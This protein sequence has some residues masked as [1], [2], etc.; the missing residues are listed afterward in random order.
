[1]GVL[2]RKNPLGFSQGSVK[3]PSVIV[4]VLSKGTAQ[5]DRT[6]KKDRYLAC[7][8]IQSYLIIDPN[9][10][11]VTVYQRQESGNFQETVYRS[12]ETIL[13]SSLGIAIHL[14][15]IYYRIL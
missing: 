14:D 11:L 15:D 6:W 2:G 8:S 3:H 12:H 1:M 13:L 5:D 7:S 9:Q 10:P 4:E